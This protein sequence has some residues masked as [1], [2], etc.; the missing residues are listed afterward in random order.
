MTFMKRDMAAKMMAAAVVVTAGGLLVAACSTLPDSSGSSKE[1][2]S[3]QCL[4]GPLE[5]TQVVDE[6]TLFAEDRSGRAALF[7]MG[8]SCLM[9]NEAVGFVFHGANQI[10]GPVD[11]DITGSVTQMP[12]HCFVKSI[13]PLTKEQAFAYK[14][15]SK[16]GG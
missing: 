16:K 7:H 15:G 11:A 5:T 1:L 12:M 10:C 14:T 3:G 8:S 9:Q 13:E 6:K 2:A 4:S